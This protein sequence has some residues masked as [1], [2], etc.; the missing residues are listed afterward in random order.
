MGTIKSIKIDV[1][2]CTGC[3]LCELACSTFHAE[4]KYSTSNPKAARI[5]VFRD[6]VNHV[7]YPI[8]AGPYTDVECLSRNTLTINDK[9]YPECHFCPASC[10]TRSMFKEPDAPEIPLK[11]D[12]CGEPTPED[13]PLCVQWCEKEAL[14]YVERE[15]REG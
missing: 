9:D 14:T 10:P 5:R 12:M 6:V 3:C 8:F 4:P 15:V 13:G 1:D 11:C 2:K 7:F